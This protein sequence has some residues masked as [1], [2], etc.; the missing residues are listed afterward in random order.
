MRV[1]FLVTDYPTSVGNPAGVFHRTLAESLVRAGATV[2]VVALVPRAP[3]PLAFLNS[4]WNEY[5]RISPRYDLGGVS[6]YRPRYWQLPRANELG[7]RHG[8]F[9]RC[10]VQSLREVPDVVHAHYAYPCGLG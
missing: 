8:S 7:V 9:A 3:S 6:V 4:R 10:L 1:A 5:R 2:D